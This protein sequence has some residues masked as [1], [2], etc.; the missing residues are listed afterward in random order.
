MK[1]IFLFFSLT[2]LSLS[3]YA[4]LSDPVV[5]EDASIKSI[6]PNGKYAVSQ[7]SS[8]LRIL[9]F[10]QANE[11]SKF[12]ES[13]YEEY[14]AGDGN[15]VSDNGVV[16]ASTPTNTNA[17]YWKDGTWH[18]LPSPSYA[19]TSNHAQGI[20]ADG[21]RI[22]GTLRVA[23]MGG[24]EDVLMVVPCI[25]N[26][27][28]NGYGS[29]V[30]L[31]HPD[32]D[33][34]NSVPQYIT[35]IDI[36]ADGKVIVGQIRDVCAL[37]YPIIYKE[38]ESGEWSFEIP[39]EYLINPDH[40]EAVPFPGDGPIMPQ[41]ESFMTQEEIDAYNE[42]Y[43]E[44]VS[45]GYQIPCPEYWE[46]MS[47]QEILAYNEAA[48]EYNEKAIAYNEKFYAWA[49]FV[50]AVANSSPNYAFNQVRISPDGKTI[51]S[52]VIVEGDNID[53]LT[54]FPKVD[55]SVWLLDLTSDKIGKYN[56]DGD[57]N[58]YYIANDGVGIATTSPGTVCNSYILENGEAID[59]VT[60]MNSKV[61][62][63]ASWI[64]ENMVFPY[65]EEVYDDKTG[66]YDFI[67]KEGVMTGRAT[68][69][70]D[71]SMISLSVQNIWDYMDDGMAYVFDLKG[72]DGVETVRPASDEMTIY[73]LSGRK[74]K[75]AKAPGI[76]IIN[77][78]KKVVR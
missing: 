4:E 45:S 23:G 64:N 78:E 8:G 61:P 60:W 55:N 72:A 66:N 71:F 74:L 40:L 68:A 47:P 70:P 51:G 58:I 35:A 12:K 24:A 9:D 28:G 14:Y 73:D 52:T 50:Y 26:A 41:F 2:A 36:S 76:Y 18:S 32:F 39:Y 46:F 29:P 53:P 21:S 5:I 15:C 69:T 43:Q 30:I 42:V 54:G 3:G 10:T 49:D 59:I 27:E 22:C 48:D 34:S 11:N 1:K 7:G 13:D 25:W 6:S 17:Q 63:Y 65:E 31:P 44:Y 57:L 62:A 75:N 37:N 77:G 20:S 16:V 19:R 38:N 67:Y 56:K 33:F